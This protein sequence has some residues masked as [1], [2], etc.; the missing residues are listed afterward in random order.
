M[1]N[2]G[3]LAKVVLDIDTVL[4]EHIQPYYTVDPHRALEE[5][6]TILNQAKAVEIAERV[7]AGYSRLKRLK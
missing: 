6:L 3:I 5:I 4:A 7:Q 1:T 2:A